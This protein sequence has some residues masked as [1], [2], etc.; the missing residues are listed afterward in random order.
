MRH[1]R[2]GFSLHFR[3]ISEGPPMTRNPARRALA[4]LLACAAALALTVVSVAPADAARLNLHRGSHGAKVRLLESRLHRIDL[5]VASAVDGRY[6]QATVNAVKSFQRRHR[7]RRTGRVNQH[8]WNL[9]ARAAKA[10]AAKSTPPPAPTGPAPAIVGHRGAVN[11][12]TPENTL[13]AMR[14]AARSAA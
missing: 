8:T 5:L 3:G 12:E 1:A 11:S 6:R 2:R 7:L 10:A 9:V 13:L 14:R 4:L